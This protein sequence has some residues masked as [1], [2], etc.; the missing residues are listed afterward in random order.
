MTLDRRIDIMSALGAEIKSKPQWLHQAVESAYHHNKWFTIANS[1]TALMAIADHFLSKEVL[2]DWAT[3]YDVK[4]TTDQKKV[5]LVLAGNI[6]LVGFHDILCCFIS[7]HHGLIKTSS[8]DDILLKSLFGWLLGHAPEL[9]NQFTLVDRLKGFEAI[10]ATGSNNSATY[11]EEYFG[12]YPNIIR[13]NRNAIA[14]LSGEE[15]DEQLHALGYDIFKYFGL[16]CRN[17]SKLYVPQDYSFDRLLG[18]LHEEHKEL[19]NHDKYRNNF[20]YNNALLLLNS[21]PY[22]MSG[23]LIVTESD[24]IA[25]RIATLH[26]AKYKD[27]TD[28]VTEIDN[29]REE[30]Q[31]VITSIDLPGVDSFQF[32][33]AQQPSITDYADGVDTMEF[34]V[35]L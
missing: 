9:E 27:T 13:K 11:F 7:G 32:G 15:S 20:D 14:I 1:W 31:C 30:I 12:K 26:Y 33:Q 17:V 21:V 18:I 28:L 23:S 5:G 22:L 35:N 10:I 6:P 16:G 2:H 24:D 19:A 3:Q 34:L 4:D 25:S 29:R 8:K